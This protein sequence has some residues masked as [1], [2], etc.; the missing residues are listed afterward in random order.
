MGEDYAYDIRRWKAV[1]E[2]LLMDN[3]PISVSGITLT[4]SG[5]PGNSGTVAVTGGPTSTAVQGAFWVVA[6]WAGGQ[7][8]E[9]VGWSVPSGS[10]ATEVAAAIAAA[11]GSIDGILATPT[12]GNV[13]VSLQG[14]GSIIALRMYMG[15][16]AGSA[17][18]GG[19][20]V[21]IPEPIVDGPN[22]S[23]HG[24][25]YW[26]QRDASQNWFIW[27]DIDVDPDPDVRQPLETF[28]AND[29]VDPNYRADV[30]ARAEALG[31]PS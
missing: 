10:T 24:A 4:R 30:Q 8:N 18:G 19:A 2:F 1:T 16:G 5:I 26:L 31:W 3:N 21:P 15:E 14:A 22:T 9:T 6:D 17:G 28:L 20:P 13:D 27:W 12:A 7:I 29:A 25:D 11:L 23:P